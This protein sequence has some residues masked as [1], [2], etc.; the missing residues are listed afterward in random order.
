[1][2]AARP[3]APGGAGGALPLCGFA[4]FTPEYFFQGEDRA[5]AREWCM[6]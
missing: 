6:R 5:A 1:M 4:A 2:S 3:S